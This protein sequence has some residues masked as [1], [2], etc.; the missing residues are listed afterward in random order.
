MTAQTEAR[1]VS[2]N[3]FNC[4]ITQTYFDSDTKGQKDLVLVQNTVS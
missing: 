1:G 4:Q 3:D 2:I